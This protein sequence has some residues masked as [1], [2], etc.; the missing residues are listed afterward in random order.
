MKHNSSLLYNPKTYSLI[1]RLR[2]SDRSIRFKNYDALIEEL[3]LPQASKGHR[4]RQLKQIQQI[5]DVS[6]IENSYEYIV[7]GYHPLDISNFSIAECEELL[8]V[9]S[10]QSHQ[11]ATPITKSQLCQTLGIW[12]DMDSFAQDYEIVVIFAHMWQ[13]LSISERQNWCNLI[14]NP[15]IFSS[16]EYRAIVHCLSDALDKQLDRYIKIFTRYGR[17]GTYGLSLKS[18]IKDL[19]WFD[20][21]PQILAIIA[22]NCAYDINPFAHI[23]VFWRQLQHNLLDA[24]RRSVQDRDPDD[25]L[26]TYQTYTVHFKN[27]SIEHL[28]K[29]IPSS[30][31]IFSRPIVI[32][33][34]EGV[35]QT[36]DTI[37]EL[38]YT[39][40]FEKFKKHCVLQLALFYGYTYCFH[41]QLSSNMKLPIPELLDCLK[42]VDIQTLSEYYNSDSLCHLTDKP[43]EQLPTIRQIAD[44]LNERP[45]ID[46]L[47]LSV[48]KNLS[49]YNQYKYLLMVY[50]F[51]I[52]TD[53]DIERVLVD[54]IFTEYLICGDIDLL[55][56]QAMWNKYQLIDIP[57]IKTH[58][59]QQTISR[60]IKSIDKPHQQTIRTLIEFCEQQNTNTRSIFYKLPEQSPWDNYQIN[61]TIIDPRDRYSQSQVL[62]EEKQKYDKTT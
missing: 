41:I 32:D 16:D 57:T 30:Q 58:I 25:S 37:H 19:L 2:T 9:L 44:A 47:V 17:S 59:H 34:P 18:H 33:T 22:K 45:D 27:E 26:Q 28:S 31:T 20:S 48:L 43:T 5:F 11:N 13:Q 60:F 61:N 14:I 53:N 39:D 8:C 12:N 36:L 49:G 4:P 46:T 42:T 3:G 55:N 10:A 51:F 23:A 7:S 54:Y 35:Q 52:D 6:R 24:Y 38:K 1:D 62:W 40:S 15:T 29:P 50:G 21:A 56:A